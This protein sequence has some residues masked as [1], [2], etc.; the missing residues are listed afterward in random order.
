MNKPL[1]TGRKI[2]DGSTEYLYFAGTSYLGLS[3]NELY[4]QLVLEGF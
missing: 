3:H 4:K 1:I 2:Y